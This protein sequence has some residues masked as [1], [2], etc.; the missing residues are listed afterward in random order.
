M[1][2]KFLCTDVLAIYCS[3]NFIFVGIGCALHIFNTSTFKLEKKIDSLYPYNIHGIVGGPNDK[4]AV[5]GANYFCTYTVHT[6]EKTLE[7]KEDTK[8]ICLK[9][10]IIASKWFAHCGIDYL[11]I[12]LAH[13]NIYIYNTS[14]EHYEETWCEEKCILYAGH[15]LIKSNKDLVVF[16]GTVFQE[17][18]IWQVN[19]ASC[20][21]ETVPILHRLQ[22]HN[23]V[24][25]SVIYDP[26]TNLICS[27]SDDRTI[28]LW[29]V[30]CDDNED[31]DDLDWKQVK[32]NLTRTMFGHTARVWRS[33]IRNGTVITIGEDSLICMWSL[34]GELLNKICA[35]HGA[36]IWSIDISD[37]NK[38]IFTGGADGAVHTWSLVN[39]YIQ[40]VIM[41]PKNLSCISP[42]YVRYLYNSNF[43]IFNEDGNL[44][45]M[46]KL[47]SDPIE[48]LYLEKYSTYCIMEVSL[49][50]SYICFASRDGYVTLYKVAD[51][52][53]DTKLVRILEE[54]LMDSQIFSIQWLE[55]NKI[56][57]CGSNGI[58]KIF[59]FSME[60]SMTIETTCILP[61][62]RE[63]WLTAA[64]LYEGLLICGDR[65]GNMH[66]FKL[67]APILPKGTNI[68]ET[69]N[70]PIQTF[71]KVHGKIG[72]QNFLILGS[73][74]VST[75][76]DGM[77]KFYELNKHENTEVLRSL[78]KEKMPMDWISGSLKIANDIL[79]LGFKEV[80][81]LMYSMFH[82]R[83]IA[84]IPCGG[85]HRSWDC[86]LLNESVMFLYIRNK[87]VHV[88]EFP[89]HS[90]KSPVLLNGFHTKEVYCIEPILK[91]DEENVLISG[92]EDGS[93]RVSTISN[94]SIKN[95]FTFRT[96]G[97]FNG[98]ISNI[99]AIVSLN[100]QT[101]HLCNKSIIFSVG[102]RAQMKIWEISIKT[103]ETLTDSDISCSDVASHMLYG[104]DQI[105]RKQWQESN[106]FY[107]I[108]PETR[109]MD[110]AIYRDT[111]NL[112]RIL[113]FLAC[114]DGF[115]RIFLYNISTRHISLKVHA[116]IVDRCITKIIILTYEGKIIALTMSTD[117]VGRF[118]D[119][120]DV[121]ST[122]LE[123]KMQIEDRELK[124]CTDMCF[125]KLNLHQSGINSYDMKIIQKNEYLLATGGDDNLFNLIHFKICT[126]SDNKQL[127][128]LLSSEWN[129]SNAHFAQI[130]GIRFHKE[131]KI[132]SVGL[133]QQINI[134]N[135]N[136]NKNILSVDILETIFTSVADVKGLTA[137]TTPKGESKICA[138]GKGFE[139]LL[140]E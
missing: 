117:G 72:I 103:G 20:S 81:F 123:E 128:I 67:E 40:R 61:S 97:I 46:N 37:D 116:K 7:I 52:A 69:N 5:F 135:Y 120:T 132:F 36:A 49:C 96:L 48:S 6:K 63:R 127:Q 44:F 50:R 68:T 26:F 108:Q 53:N 57:A 42:K 88:F 58:L 124:N 114:A 83:T 110:I 55:N 130:T 138:Y 32:I 131:N 80:E 129:T 4:L 106:Q 119:F 12:L 86:M 133:D 18:L 125:A 94:I 66:I 115:V 70:K 34:E 56:I 10:W 95:N 122:V 71:T 24:I 105:R 14:N 47:H 27:T 64:T 99:K 112:H 140:C 21:M 100:F 126:S 84:R 62:S 51:S 25:F 104:S 107:I 111:Q 82:R 109:Y 92:G 2:S 87:R 43:S 45:V 39:S 74:L 22:G 79:I 17:I 1:I 65:S 137:W 134:Y 60:G 33:I 38:Y 118:I 15:M 77:L 101:G 23:G 35:H 89:L 9:D 102:G 29:T 19:H 31:K 121:V 3:R 16:S 85:G 54:K 90:M 91:L 78:H 75:G 76:R 73:K 139:V 93:L 8:K 113:L 30:N 28:R 13:N 11:A 59:V 136:F 98:H 41:L